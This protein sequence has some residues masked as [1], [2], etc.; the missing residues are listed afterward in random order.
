MPSPYC[1]VMNG[2]AACSCYWKSFF[3]EVYLISGS[4]YKAHRVP[5]RSNLHKGFKCES[6]GV[7]YYWEETRLRLCN[8]CGRITL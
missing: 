3:K 1:I 4:V 6:E 7:R 8:Y 5:W 2:I